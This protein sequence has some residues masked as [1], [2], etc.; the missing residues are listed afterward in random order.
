MAQIID[1]KVISN[2][3]KDELNAKVKEYKD[4]GTEICLAVMQAGNDPASTI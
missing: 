1:G 2:Q 4:N 3:I